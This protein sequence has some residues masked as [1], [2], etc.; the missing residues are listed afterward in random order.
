MDIAVCQILGIE[1]I[2]IPV[3]RRAKVRGL[4]PDRI[5]YPIL[6]PEAVAHEG[7][8]LPNTA[9]HVLTG[10]KPPSKSPVVTDQCIACGDCESICPKDAIR[11]SGQLAEV[12]YSQ[13]I[14]CFC[15][16]EVCPEDAIVLRSLKQRANA[17]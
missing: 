2:R 15:C 14:R 16:H 17:R 6:R 12:T 7:F 11:V 1:P 5:D 9:E 4:W 13:C 10:K 3:L 8:R